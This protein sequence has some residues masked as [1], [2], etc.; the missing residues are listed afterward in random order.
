MGLWMNF[1]EMIKWIVALGVGGLLA[2]AVDWVLSKRSR[3]VDQVVKLS[4]AYVSLLDELQ[5]ERDGLKDELHGLLEWK[6]DAEKRI[7]ALMAKDRLRDE[8]IEKL[9]RRIEELEQENRCL[10]QRVAELEK[11]GA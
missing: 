7:Q 11:D 9:G 10:R 3:K 1:D 6:E 2:K 4:D 8:L 5:E